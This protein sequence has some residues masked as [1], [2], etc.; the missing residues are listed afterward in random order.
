MLGFI[1]K[2]IRESKGLTKA[3]L[4]RL[5]GCTRSYIG[6]VEKNQNDPTISKLDLICRV[7]SVQID[8]LLSLAR[9]YKDQ[10]CENNAEFLVDIQDIINGGALIEFKDSISALKYLFK[11]NSNLD[12]STLEPKGITEINNQVSNFINILSYKYN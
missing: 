1:I 4:A 3:E 5:V 9:K 6:L 7:L 12:L 8:D 10:N 11:E 2:T